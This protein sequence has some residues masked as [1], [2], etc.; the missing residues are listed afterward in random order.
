MNVFTPGGPE[1][2]R[3]Q[4][5]GL[6]K[7]I[8][9]RGVAALLFDPGLGK[10]ATVIDYAGLLTLK[11]P[12]GEARVLV[13]CPLVALDT[14]VSQVALFASPQIHWW[15][16]AL[17]GSITQRGEALA[18]RGGRSAARKGR[19]AVLRPG[20]S[21]RARHRA[22]SLAH[23]TS[24]PLGPLAGPES[25]PS[26]RLVL[27]VIN[28]DTLSSRSRDPN[29]PS[30]LMSDLMVD[31]ITRFAPD[32]VVVDESHKIKSA[33]GNASRLL[34][35]V[36]HHVPRRVILTGTVMPHSPLDVFGQWR[37]LDPYAFG[38]N[39]TTP[40]TYT[41]FRDR[42]AVMGGFMGRQVLSFR[43]LD[44]MQD[45]MA[46]N[47]VVAR[48]DDALDL[49]PTTDVI[50]PVTLSRAEQRAYDEM[51]QSLAAQLSSGAVTVKNRLTQMMRLRQITSGHLPDDTG[52]GGRDRPVQGGH[53]RQP[54]ARHPGRGVPGG[55]LR[56]V[57]RRDR[58]ADQAAGPGGHRGGGDPGLDTDRGTPARTG[59][60][61]APPSRP[62]W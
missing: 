53:D 12:V 45:V 24:E 23:A 36:A 13:I 27:E 10:T 8:Q 4:R 44:E 48:K 39:A 31:A 32:L 5:Q 47:A 21:P 56:A 17:G 35:R 42:Y 19:A 60:G 26:P 34:A 29:K 2:F 37:F 15:A 58:D 6:A 54:G 57:H 11:S 61:S 9:T 38:P 25:L 22:R 14:W 7:M 18:A 33:T 1:R 50:V 51:K 62:G 49:P 43:H 55:D 40:A 3:H 59:S 20:E 28:I 30:Q 16:E 46:R 41:A 52:T